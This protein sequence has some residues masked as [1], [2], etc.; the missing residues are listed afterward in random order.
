MV[1]QDA[2][3]LSVVERIV[4]IGVEDEAIFSLDNASFEF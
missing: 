3:L 2:E 4:Y 1:Q